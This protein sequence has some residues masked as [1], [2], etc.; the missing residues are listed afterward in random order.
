MV[1]VKDLPDGFCDRGHL[2]RYRPTLRKGKSIMCS[3]CNT[4]FQDNNCIFT[5]HCAT[6]FACS[7]CLSERKAFDPPPNCPN[8]SCT[9][10][11]TLRHKG[12]ITICYQ[13]KAEIPRDI[14]FWN[15]SLSTCRTIICLNCVKQNAPAN[16][17]AQ[18]AND[19]ES[20]PISHSAVTSHPCSP[21]QHSESGQPAPMLDAV[22]H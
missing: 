14:K 12:I 10:K 7:K 13:C 4:S 1:Q 6:F 9:G 15:C 8:L 3:C 21:Q 5:C 2:V 18:S 17:R 22:G 11:C 20:P 19:H 16:V